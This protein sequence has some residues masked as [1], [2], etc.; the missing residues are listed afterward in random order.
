MTTET[1]SSPETLDALFALVGF[2]VLAIVLGVIALSPSPAPPSPVITPVVVRWE[3][4]PAP[5]ESV[6]R[7]EFDPTAEPDNQP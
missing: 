3:S 5:A 6:D 1:V 7:L 2:S 4:T